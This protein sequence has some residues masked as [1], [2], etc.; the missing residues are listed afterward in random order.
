MLVAASFYIDVVDGFLALQS[1]LL[2]TTAHK[3]H[4]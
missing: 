1:R 3:W 4:L 2:L